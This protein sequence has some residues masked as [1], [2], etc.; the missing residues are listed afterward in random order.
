MTTRI[1]FAAAALAL[2]AA[3][4]NLY[5]TWCETNATVRAWP[6][7]DPTRAID[8]RSADLVSRISVADKVQ[9]LAGGQWGQYS[10]GMGG[11]SFPSVGISQGYKCVATMRSF[12]LSCARCAR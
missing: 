2:A 3:Q 9:A 7:C 1:S 12:A 11:P 4:P 10:P 5:A 8:E 6:I